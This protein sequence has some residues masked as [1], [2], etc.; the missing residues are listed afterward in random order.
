MTPT[1]LGNPA[2]VPPNITASNWGDP[3]AKILSDSNGQGSGTGLGNG[4]GGGIGPGQEYGVGGGTPKR[5]DGRLRR[6]RLR[7]LPQTGLYR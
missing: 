1:V 6:S 2:I 7:L 3:L 4:N 5:G